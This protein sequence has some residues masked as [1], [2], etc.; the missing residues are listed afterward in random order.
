MPSV[1]K[2]SAVLTLLACT[3]C[4]SRGVSNDAADDVAAG[5]PAGTAVETQAHGSGSGVSILAG[6]TPASGSTV[7]APVNQLK[8]RFSPPARLAEVTVTGPDGTMPMMV[9]AVG[10]VADYSLPL[11]E[12]NAGK[13]TVDWRAIV[14]AQSHKGS[15]SFTVR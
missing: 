9:T 4:A 10:E 2:K 14:G 8:L 3:A 13:Y 11:D 15:F 7:G 12:L 5:T 6:S 1:W